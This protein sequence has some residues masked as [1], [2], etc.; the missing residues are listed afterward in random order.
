MADDPYKYFR[1]EARELL[2]QLN[3]SV[4]ALEKGGSTAEEVQRI[5]RLAHTLKGAARVVKQKAMADCAHAIEE[6]VSAFRGLDEAVPR[7]RVEVVLHLL[8]DIAAGLA[9]LDAPEAVQKVASSAPIDDAFRTVRAD[10]SEMDALIDGISETHVQLTT[11]KGTLPLLERS[12]QI[13]ELLLAQLRVLS[14]AN[15]GQAD[16]A[17]GLIEELG[18]VL[19]GAQRNL[20]GGSEQLDRELRQVRESSQRLRLLPVNLVFT[21][22]ERTALDAA[23][24]LGKSVR[25][26]SR[27]GDIRLDAQVLSSL[28]GALIQVVRNAVA[29]GVEMPAKRNALGK[30]AQGLVSVEVARRGNRVCFVCRDDGAGVDLNAVRTAARKTGL[31]NSQ[32]EQ[33]GAS[34]LVALLLRGGISTSATVTAVS[35]R[36]IG[37]DVVREVL[38]RLGGEVNVQTEAGV[39][40]TLELVVPASLTGF[41]GLVVQAAGQTA[42]IPLEAVSAT[43]RL[44]PSQITQ[45]TQG[46][47]IL[48]DGDVIPFAQL[49][50]ALRA[51][52]NLAHLGGTCP[53]VVI[54]SG[55][56]RIALGV[57]RLLGIE[58]VVLRPLPRFAPTD[59]IISG[60]TIDAEGNPRI[61]L[62]AESLAD[63]PQTPMATQDRNLTQAP[64]LIIDDSLTTRM[65]ERSILESAGYTVDMASSGE[66]GLRKLEQTAYALCLIDVEMPGMS[67]FE[68]IERIRADARLQHI[69]AILV[70]SR[71]APEDLQRG[72][73]VGA[74]DYVV[75]SA[76]D[77]TR[78]LGRIAELTGAR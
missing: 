13:Q 56:K 28:Q 10:V 26:E 7:H 47:A 17:L 15:P 59:A 39:G 77:Q 12:Q 61:V 67:G 74:Q 23:H 52:D 65:L 75:K 51:P 3:K 48:V 21:V 24:D 64:I 49:A 78:L 36:G 53:V 31:F 42:V 4:L 38:A 6:A 35:G 55:E 20:K 44:D 68:V 25:F 18:E 16:K 2:E 70:T 58:D 27:G 72:R 66:E 54:Q 34:E 41:E 30:P 69:P 73:V 11:L 33:L 57:D 19:T 29:H 9:A 63:A 45:S 60:A 37:L 14:R 5:L 32:T 8:A 50:L 40:T 22:L 62:N 1:I 46:A 43:L 76:F 71:N